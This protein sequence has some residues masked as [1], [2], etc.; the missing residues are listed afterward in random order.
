MVSQNSLQSSIRLR[1]RLVDV[2]ALDLSLLLALSKLKITADLVVDHRHHGF[3]NLVI[4]RAAAEVAGHPFFDLILG[5]FG[6]FVEE[7]FSSHNL[8]GCTDPALEPAVFN[9]SLL[10]WMK[11][12]ILCE[13]FDGFDI[14][15]LAS[16]GKCQTRTYDTAVDDHT[17]S[18]ANTDAATFLGTGE[19]DIIPQN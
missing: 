6:V 12:T 19:A 17:T 9:E 13:P 2:K 5:W 8:T 3:Q 4:A 1:D 15:A 14:L 11:L 10:Q 7:R 18:P 16:D